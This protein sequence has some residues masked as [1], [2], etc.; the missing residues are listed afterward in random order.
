MALHG[1]TVA[2]DFPLLPIAL[3]DFSAGDYTFR[4]H[5]VDVDGTFTDPVT[6]DITEVG[7]EITNSE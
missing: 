4:T 3:P 2:L 7:V 6:G 1:Q 5:S